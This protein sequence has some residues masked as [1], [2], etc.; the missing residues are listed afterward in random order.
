MIRGV[1]G[2]MKEEMISESLF[3]DFLSLNDPI[4]SRFISQIPNTLSQATKDVSSIIERKR[5]FNE[6]IYD[7]RK[8]LKSM[9]EKFHCD[10]DTLTDNIKSSIELLENKN[11]HIQV[12]LHQP[13]LF[14]Y[15]GVFKK[16]V[17]L[18]TIKQKVLERKPETKLINLFVFIDHDFLNNIWLRLAQLP[19]IKNSSGI[20]DIR[21][22]FNNNLK[23]KV[24]GNTPIPRESVLKRW[25]ENIITWIKRSTENLPPVKRLELLYNFEEFWN[26]IVEPSYRKSKSYADLNSYIISKI[27][28]HSWKYDTLFV[29]LTQLSPILEKSYKKLILEFD[30]Y[31]NSIK[32]TEDLFTKNKITTGISPRSYLYSPLWLHCNCGSKAN[33][34]IKTNE[35]SGEMRLTGKC[36]GCKKDLEI[37]MGSRHNIDDIKEHIHRLSPKAVPI[38]LAL[39]DGLG[40]TSISSGTGGSVN[41]TIFSTRIF[42]EMSINIPLV[43]IWSSKDKYEGFAQ[44][45]A[46]SLLSGIKQTEILKYIENLEYKNSEYKNV[47]IPLLEQRTLINENKGSIDLLLN[48]LFKLK[49][50]QRNIRKKIKTTQKARNALSLNPCIIDYA[51]N[52]GIEEIE[53]IWKDN[54]IINENLSKYVLI[55]NN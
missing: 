26:F 18:N 14:A 21:I 40:I 32:N 7:N 36:M 19:S 39:S 12:I 23:W 37:S 5:M 33:T 24:I 55:E 30:K 47:I 35:K 22:P 3:S 28:N 27:V 25:R 50:E 53:R 48:D 52:F 51:T 41:Y 8:K 29:R 46:K 4:I 6:S 1:T 16:I 54:L 11:T 20:L 9:V 49:Q 31:A 10:S 43:I 15:S 38:L 17:L 13:N 2:G 45:D 34:K 44:A 42:Q